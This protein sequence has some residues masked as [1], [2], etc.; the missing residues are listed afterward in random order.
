MY[1]LA[2]TRLSALCILGLVAA[3]TSSPLRAEVREWALANNEIKINAELCN[4]FDGIAYFKRDDLMY[5]RLPLK[6]LAKNEI[7]KIIQWAKER[8]A[9][10]PETIEQS[11]GQLALD[12]HTLWPNRF[13][14]GKLSD[15]VDINKIQ[16]PKFFAMLMVKRTTAELPDMVKALRKAEV[17]INA[18]DSHFMEILAITPDSDLEFRELRDEI[19]RNGGN[20]LMPNE[21]GIKSHPIL[22][23]PYWRIP[24]LSVVIMDAKGTLLCDSTGKEPDGTPQDV[25]A[26][27]NKMGEVA[28]RVRAGGCSVTNPLV[29]FNTFN[30]LLA[31]ERDKKANH[32]GPQPVFFGFEGMDPADFSALEGRTFKVSMLIAAD[33]TVRSLSISEGG[34]PRAEAAFK[35]ASMLWQFFPAMKDGVPCDKQ[36]IVPITLRAPKPAEAA[37][38]ADK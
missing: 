5:I 6:M 22:W 18:G 20:W 15:K 11:H 1:K 19:S 16:V 14:N 8:D 38:P 4:A 30:N 36:V 34:D 12:I 10:P 2:S 37:R 28:A 21:W 26:F 13:I 27:L 25:V 3:L 24:Y 32:P 31:A 23:D 17:E 9:L 29:N 7:A 33:G 35:Q